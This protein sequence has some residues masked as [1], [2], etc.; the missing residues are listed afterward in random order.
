MKSL[1][2]LTYNIQFGPRKQLD[3]L[4][5]VL[6]A[7][8]ADVIALN[9]AD[10]EAV[11]AELADRLDMHHVWA[12]GS[13]ARHV[14]TLSRFPI[15]KWQIYN[16]KPLTQAA[17]ATVLDFHPTSAGPVTVY[18][19][20]LRPDPYWHF[21]LLRWLA[22]GKLLQVIRQQTPGSH[23]LVGDLNTYAPGDPVQADVILRH[24]EQGRWILQLQR[25]RFLRIAFA[26]LLKAGYRDCFRHLH[27]TEPGFTFT[28]KGELVA[29]MDYILADKMFA[30]ALQSCRVV[31]DV[32]GVHLASDHYPVLA[33]FAWGN[34]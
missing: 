22:V 14:A 24:I 1:R 16:R 5:T 19:V 12:R 11:V 27:P 31:D 4:H 26:R 30:A 13:G 2:V 34:G 6:A 25:Y 18:N 10:D 32:A 17:L 15:L 33:E 29:R 20:H 8:A 3:K 7:C 23:L 21:E 9:E 28:R